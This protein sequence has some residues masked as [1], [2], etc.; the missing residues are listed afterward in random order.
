MD[1]LLME[2]IATMLREE[3]RMLRV[4]MCH[5]FSKSMCMAEQGPMCPPHPSHNVLAPEVMVDDECF[6]ESALL[7]PFVPAAE[8]I[9]EHVTQFTRDTTTSTSWIDESVLPPPFVPTPEVKVA[10]DD[11]R[12]LFTDNTEA[13]AHATAVGDVTPDKRGLTNIS[14]PVRRIPT[15]NVVARVLNVVPTTTLDMPSCIDNTMDCNIIPKSHATANNLFSKAS[16]PQQSSPCGAASTH[17]DPGRCA[18]S[19][20]V[21]VIGAPHLD[22]P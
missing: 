10:D 22:L 2:E 7:P 1:P 6:T 11:N 8:C 19:S 21:L 13:V 5:A 20:T 12:R 9:S 3:L 17:L 14:S 15:S 18:Q 16:P 4:E